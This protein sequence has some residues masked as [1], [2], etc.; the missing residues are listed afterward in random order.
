MY[1]N[2]SSFAPRQFKGTLGRVQPL[3]SG[4][5]QQD[6]QEFLS[7]LVDALH[8]DLNRVHKKPYR[9]NP[10]SDDKTVHDPE[11]IQRLG[12]VYRENHQARNNSIIM[13]LFSGFYKNTMVCPVCDKVS[14][15]FDP[16]SS[17]TLQLPIETPWSHTITVWP[18]N[19][20]PIQMEV[21]LDKNSTV[22]AL[23]TFVAK[24]LT[25]LK[26]N[27]LVL[28]EIFSEKFYR[29]FEDSDS[30]SEGTVNSNDKLDLFELD[31]SPTN[32]FSETKRPRGSLI[33]D[34]APAMD[35]PIADR[36]A[37]PLYHRV[38]DSRDRPSLELWPTIITI[39][40]DEAKDYDLIL[41]RV[42]Y[43]VNS[44][45]TL[46]LL[47]ETGKGRVGQL[48]NHGD[49]ETSSV[50]DDDAPEDAKIQAR[51]VEG[52]DGLVDISMTGTDSPAHDDKR[53][54][55]ADILDA[56]KPLD[57]G[58]R[59]LFSMCYF[60]APSEPFPC[61]YSG[62]NDRTRY[63]TIYSRLQQTQ[64][65]SPRS[66]T[67]SNSGSHVLDQNSVA[68]SD[69]ELSQEPTLRPSQLEAGSDS[70]ADMGMSNMFSAGNG[71]TRP[72]NS[73]QRIK[74]ARTQDDSDESEY[75]LRLREGIVL[76]WDTQAFET[77]FAG[78]Q[79]DDLRGHPIFDKRDIETFHDSEL[80]AKQS[81]RNL[82]KKNGVSL[83]DCFEETAKSEVLSEENAWYCGR[84]K[85]LRRATKTLELWTTP[86]ILVLH[87]KRFSSQSR[88]RDKVDVLVDFPVQNLDL[89]GRIGL[90]DDKSQVYDLFA[91][92]NH[93]G[94]LG[95]GHYTAYAQNFYDKK[96][97]NHDGKLASLS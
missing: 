85:E 74:A 42:L 79:H 66:V 64:L 58:L 54:A 13:D 16:Y 3:F 62:V 59:T 61:G 43:K 75:L 1:Q 49:G 50:A 10:D 84:C 24:R 31:R 6:S 92:D 96:W 33:A 41:R 97:Y 46:N 90:P 80:E 47:E 35:S 38:R 82:R 22:R 4:Y 60:S 2:V 5:G 37:V 19:A 88:L 91:V 72:K 11:A 23:K 93:Y 81:R 69:D 39:T 68:S 53:I 95:G 30:L 52:E 14:I 20:K 25:S 7:F 28:A 17:V 65:R 78:E 40:R 26:P 12:Q 71:S 67:T 89:S 36:M 15:T 8:E 48:Q 18:L 32:W 73:L 29:V 63:P 34:E 21:E 51:S 77:I 87:L 70:D 57:P 76:D 9:E 27:H 56:G 44:M 86:D 83:I 45:T 55:D 94:G